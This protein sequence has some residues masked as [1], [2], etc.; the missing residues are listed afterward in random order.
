MQPLHNSYVSLL[1]YCKNTKFKQERK[2]FVSPP[3]TEGL[4]YEQKLIYFI[5]MQGFATIN[6]EGIFLAL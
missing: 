4:Q 3:K 5:C 6:Q 1:T 2:F